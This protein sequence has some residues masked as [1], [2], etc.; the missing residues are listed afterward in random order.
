MEFTIIYYP[1]QCADC[2]HSL[3]NFKKESFYCDIYPKCERS[4]RDL[5]KTK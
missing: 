5:I 3:Y 2:K 4:K 1:K